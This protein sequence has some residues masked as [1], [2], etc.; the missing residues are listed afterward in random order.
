[1]DVK[2]KNDKV[3]DVQEKN[4]EV[5][6]AQEKNDEVADVQEKNDEVVDVQEKNDEPQWSDHCIENLVISS[7]VDPN[8]VGEITKGGSY[9]DLSYH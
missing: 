6:Y 4:D 5:S 9:Y 3:A 2:G 8:M 7:W 1:M